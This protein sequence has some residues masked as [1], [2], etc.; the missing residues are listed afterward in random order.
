MTTAKGAAFG[1]PPN[2]GGPGSPG[3]SLPLVLQERRGQ[4]VCPYCQDTYVHF[5]SPH[6]HVTDNYTCPTGERGNWID[7]PMWCEGGEHHWHLVVAFHK[8]ESFVHTV[9]GF[10]LNGTEPLRE[11]RRVAD[12]VQR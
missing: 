1:P 12:A 4:L 7:I 6:E 5:E 11:R 10:R 9:D 8:G 3:P 2:N